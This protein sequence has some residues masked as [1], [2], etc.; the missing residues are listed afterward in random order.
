VLMKALTVGL[1]F[2]FFTNTSVLAQTK[3]LGGQPA[4]GAKSSVEDFQAQIVYQ[5][6]FEAVIW[7]M[8]AVAI[9]RMRAGAFSALGASDNEIWAYSRPCTYWPN[10]RWSSTLQPAPADGFE[11]VTADAILLDA[12]R[13]IFCQN[14][15]S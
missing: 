8:P 6:A 15:L 14:L 13:S 2:L 10:R 11:Y 5:R 7:S 9:Y 3:P 12:R 1:L 4:L